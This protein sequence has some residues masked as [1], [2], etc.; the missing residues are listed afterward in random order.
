FGIVVVEELRRRRAPAATRPA[1]GA[2]NGRA[3]GFTLQW[4]ARIRNGYPQ[5]ECWMIGQ[6]SW[7]I[8]KAAGHKEP[9]CRNFGK[10]PTD[11]KIRP[12]QG[13][14]KLHFPSFTSINTRPR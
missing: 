1:I 3:H 7:A 13:F 14:T 8:K 5:A 11:Q 10:L 4:S 6:V 12:P 2:G 9:A